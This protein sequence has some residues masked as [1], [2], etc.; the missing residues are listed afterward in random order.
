M[1]KNNVGPS[2]LRTSYTT[3]HLAADEPWLRPGG[4]GCSAARLSQIHTYSIGSRGTG[5]CTT[6]ATACSS[7]MVVAIYLDLEPTIIE[8]LNLFCS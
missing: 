1:V 4:S 7:A 8:P 6:R 2:G 3:V 5:P